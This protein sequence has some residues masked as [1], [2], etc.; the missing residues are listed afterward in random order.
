MAGG[1]FL[2]ARCVR[3]PAVI[4]PATAHVPESAIP[5]TTTNFD[6]LVTVSGLVAMVDF[7]SPLCPHCV[8]MNPVVDSI[9]QAFAGRALVGKVNVDEDDLLQNRF[10]V[11]SWP[12]FVFLKGGVEYERVVGEVSGDSLAAVM[13]RGLAAGDI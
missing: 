4:D 7:F 9:A 11:Y 10:A 13:E 8:T 1:M 5:L 2:F 12:T 3:G 6:S